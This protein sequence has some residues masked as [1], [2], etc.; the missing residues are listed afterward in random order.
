M[1]FINIIHFFI[2][3]LETESINLPIYLQYYDNLST[4]VSINLIFPFK[5][6]NT[7]Y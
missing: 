1:I 3:F 2:F 5:F 7:S 4:L 6:S